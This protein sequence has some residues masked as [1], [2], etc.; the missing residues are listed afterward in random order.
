MRKIRFII[1]TILIIFFLIPSGYCANNVYL[2]PG[3]FVE[4]NISVT[5]GDTIR[6]NYK[7]YDSS[8]QVRVGYCYLSCNYFTP[9]DS[10]GSFKLFITSSYGTVEIFFMNIDTHGGYLEYSIRRQGDDEDSSYIMLLIM[11]V[12]IVGA[13]FTSIGIGIHFYSKYKNRR[14]ID[15]NELQES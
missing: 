1:L 12:I 5:A 3:E 15:D 7:T 4:K 13:V 14:I 2:N 9:T 8:F 6:V 10:S 11:G